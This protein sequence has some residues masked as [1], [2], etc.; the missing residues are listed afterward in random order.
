MQITDHYREL[1]ST[2]ALRHGERLPTVADIADRV[3][4]M[5]AGRIVE[6]G[7]T[8][9]LFYRPKH[10]Y[11]EALL[12]ALPQPDPRNRTEAVPLTGDV[13]S[14]ANPPSGCYFHTRCPYAQEICSTETPPLRDV[15]DET[16]GPGS[17]RQAACHFAEQLDLK[18]ALVPSAEAAGGSV[19][20]R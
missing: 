1:I 11:T 9:E 2:G 10:P 19:D 14:P 4:V 3:A 20:A 7:T 15:P 6:T 12:S 13:P 5:Y 16:A 17:T 18:G 8:R